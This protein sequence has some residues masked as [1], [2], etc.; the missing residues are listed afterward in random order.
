MKGTFSTEVGL[1][2]IWDSASMSFIKTPDDGM[3][4]MVGDASYGD[5]MTRGFGVFWG[6][7]GD[8]TYDVDVR[9]G[10]DAT[11]TADEQRLIEMKAEN[12]K[13]VATSER[14]IVGSPE[15]VGFAESEGLM[16]KRISL[17][18]N[19]QSGTYAVDLYFIYDGEA[20][21]KMGDMS[22]TEVLALPEG[23]DKTGFVVLVRPVDSSHRFPEN[24]ILPT[25]G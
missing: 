9:V 12:N 6:T 10:S 23:F 17:V 3:K 5:H 1:L 14:V 13:L 18:Q 7:G 19:I 24:I 15:Y 8:G 22:R 16:Q 11:L 4:Y 21:E 2:G 20:E 25:L